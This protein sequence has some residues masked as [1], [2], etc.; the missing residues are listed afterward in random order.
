MRYVPEEMLGIAKVTRETRY[1]EKGIVYGHPSVVE[2]D[3]IVKDKEHILVEVKSRISRGD[4]AEIYRIGKLYE[5]V[6]GINPKLPII[7]GFIDSRAWNTARKLEV[8]L[9]PAFIAEL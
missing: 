4:V 7:G 9:K 6:H 3:L 2:V 1:D 8:E 5:E